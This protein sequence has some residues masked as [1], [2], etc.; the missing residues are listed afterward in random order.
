M[1][2]ILIDFEMKVASPIFD[3]NPSIY[4]PRFLHG[5]ESKIKFGS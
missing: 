5:F 4:S 1:I 3:K 2:S